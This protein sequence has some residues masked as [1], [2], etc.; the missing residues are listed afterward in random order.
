LLI[1]KRLK[2]PEARRFVRLIACQQSPFAS[3][4]SGVGHGTNPLENGQR[5]GKLLGIVRASICG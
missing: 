5:S 4:S 3:D 1:A 2:H